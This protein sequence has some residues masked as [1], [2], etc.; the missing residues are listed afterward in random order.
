MKE[1]WVLLNSLTGPREFADSLDGADVIV[2]ERLSKSE[3]EKLAGGP[4]RV[5]SRSSDADIRLTDHAEL[6]SS[7]LKID[8]P[9][10]A[11]VKIST[12]ED[13]GK[14][15]DALACGA[16][17]VIVRCSDWKVIPLEN[18]VSRTRHSGKILMEV[19]DHNQARV[20]LQTLE[21]GSDGVLLNSM[22]S[23]ELVKTSALIHDQSPDMSLVEV[24][25][26]GRNEIGLGARVCVDTTDLLTPGEG[27]LVGCQSNALFL[28]Q[29]EVEENPYI[30][31]RPFR[32]NAGPV[33]QYIL[34]SKDKTNYLSELE[35]GHSI[36]I[37]NR[38]GRARA[39]HI[40]RVKIEWRPLILIEANWQGRKV[41]AILQNAETIK[42][43]TKD[44]SKSVTELEP[45]DLI[46]ARVE[47]GGR[48]FGTLV[49]EESVVEK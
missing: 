3:I 37:V 16:T 22:S 20:A 1:L 47:K 2:S 8:R 17:Y 48:H 14:V 39:G 15:E 4:V 18:V 25:V 43:M 23:E 13:E 5:A 33:S 27:M 45:G 6:R 7:D 38:E 49:D 31:S 12:G 34:T 36:L 24:E 9:I 32:V 11:T 28:V 46:L 41:K 44:G 30:S 40:G 21:I 19:T 10:A 29:A 35:A 26:T 42:L